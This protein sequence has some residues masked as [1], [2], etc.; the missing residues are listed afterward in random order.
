MGCCVFSGE[1]VFKNE[2]VSGSSNLG[3]CSGSMRILRI[4]GFASLLRASH[5]WGSLSIVANVLPGSSEVKVH[6]PW[7]SLP[8]KSSTFSKINRSKWQFLPF[9]LS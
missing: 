7:V 6:L 2:T 3:M 9:F 5:K 4:S 8:H 1:V